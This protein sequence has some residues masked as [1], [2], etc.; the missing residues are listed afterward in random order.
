[1]ADEIKK[2]IEIVVEKM[3]DQTKIISEGHQMLVERLDRFEAEVRAR[4]DSLETEMRAGFAE[5]KSM[6]KFS[7]AELDARI[8]HLEREVGDLRSRLE[9]IEARFAS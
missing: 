2:Y 4:F 5:V 8:T 7:H 3:A 6:I 9:K 1:M